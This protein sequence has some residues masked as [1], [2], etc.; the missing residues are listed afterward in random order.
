VVAAIGFSF[1]LAPTIVTAATAC[2]YLIPLALIASAF[3]TKLSALAPDVRALEASY[4]PYPVSTLV[5][6]I[7]AIRIAN[8]N[9]LGSHDD[10]A[11]RLDRAVPAT[12]VTAFGLGAQ[13]LLALH[14]LH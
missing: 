4:P 13:L 11:S 1:R 9:M 8:E 5:E 14:L 2:L 3:T 10:K 7:R 6:A 12:L